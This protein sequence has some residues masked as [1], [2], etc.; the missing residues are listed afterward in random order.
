MN[1]HTNQL[2]RD[3][4]VPLDDASLSSALG[5]CYPVYEKF[6]GLLD[7]H[8]LTPHWRYYTDGSAWLMK[9]LYQWTGARG[10]QTF[11]KIFIPLMLPTL[12]AGWSFLFARMV[13]DLTATALLAGGSNMVVGFRMLQIS[14][15]GTFAQLASIAVSVSVVTAVVVIF[16][17]Y[18]SR[19]LN[20]WSQGARKPARKLRKA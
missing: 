13:G 18:L 19:V 9:G 20:K 1:D 3:E 12:V 10:G 14:E 4:N 11:F 2:L 16:T 6:I 17:Q 7:E 5:A 15:N 8:C